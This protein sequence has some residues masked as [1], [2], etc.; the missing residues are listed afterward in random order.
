MNLPY[1]IEIIPDETTDGGRCYLVMHPELP[2]CMSHGDT[3][4]EAL[5]NLAEARRLYIESL[6][7]RGI[8]VPH[9]R[10]VTAGTGIAPVATWEVAVAIHPKALDE[11]V[12]ATTK[13]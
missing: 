10:A 1:A 9:P 7:E 4:A 13:F 12:F 6:L 5:Q 11:E 2:G 3:E 8:E